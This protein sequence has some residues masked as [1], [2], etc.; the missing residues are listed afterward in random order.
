MD[1]T[2]R[3]IRLIAAEKNSNLVIE[4]KVCPQNCSHAT[5]DKSTDTSAEGAVD[6]GERVFILCKADKRHRSNNYYRRR[7]KGRR[8][9]TR[10]VKFSNDLEEN[11]AKIDEIID[12]FTDLKDRAVRTVLSHGKTSNVAKDVKREMKDVVDRFEAV[13]KLW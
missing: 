13:F 2:D 3:I 1:Y 7:A 6:K 9:T 11:F 5:H 4:H 8:R 10:A 12:F